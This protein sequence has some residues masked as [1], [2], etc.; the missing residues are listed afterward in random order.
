MEVEYL[1]ATNESLKLQLT[2]LQIQMKK[3]VKW[4]KNWNTMF[5]IVLGVVVFRML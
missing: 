4:E 1:R 2:E 5:C 3:V